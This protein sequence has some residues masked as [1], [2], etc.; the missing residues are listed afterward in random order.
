MFSEGSLGDHVNVRS[1]LQEQLHNLCVAKAGGQ[2]QRR[3]LTLVKHRH[4][5]TP[6][7]QLANQLHMTLQILACQTQKIYLAKKLPNPVRM[8]S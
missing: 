6:L 7:A 4:R 2:V 3:H 5:A 1:V 8:V